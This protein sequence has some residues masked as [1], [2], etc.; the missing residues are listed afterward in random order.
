MENTIMKLMTTLIGILFL[1]GV[2]VDAQDMLEKKF[3]AVLGEWQG[4][5]EGF[6]GGRSKIKSSFKLVMEGQYLEVL[7]NSEFDP[8]EQHPEG[9]NH[10]DRG[11]IS[12]DKNRSKFIYRQFNIEGY[13]NQYVLN[14]EYSNDSTFIFETETIENFIPDGKARLTIHIQGSDN[15]ETIFDVYFPGEDYTCYGTN[16]LSRE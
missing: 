13:V 5:G 8:T 16:H 11:Y 9:E 15:I 10:I 4:T 7:N 12:Y 1:S 14:E 3:D 2:A 6:S